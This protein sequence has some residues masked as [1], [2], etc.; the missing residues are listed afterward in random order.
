MGGLIDSGRFIHIGG[1]DDTEGCT[2]PRRRRGRSA[3]L[4]LPLACMDVHDLTRQVKPV[5]VPHQTRV[6][7]VGVPPGPGVIFQND[8]RDL[9]GR[10]LL[11]RHRVRLGAT[12]SRG[13]RVVRSGEVGEELRNDIGL[14]RGSLF[15]GLL[16]VA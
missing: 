15:S 4:C 3:R 16:L 1:C 9:L 13:W 14:L 11:G 6:G 2:D 5:P 8:G 12:C 10:D 7:R